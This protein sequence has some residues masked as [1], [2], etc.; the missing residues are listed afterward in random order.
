M[1][2][3]CLKHEG[4]SKKYGYPKMDGFIMENPIKLDDLWVPLFSE[5]RNI[6]VEIVETSSIQPF[7]ASPFTLD[8]S[9]TD[10]FVA[11]PGDS[12]CLVSNHVGDVFF[13]GICWFNSWMDSKTSDSN[14]VFF[15][16]LSW[17]SW[18]AVM[19]RYHDQGPDLGVIFFLRSGWTVELAEKTDMG[20]PGRNVGVSFEMGCG[21]ILA[22]EIRCPGPPNFKG[23]E[24]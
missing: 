11:Q 21:S 4:V 9:S 1:N 10:I 18:T 24:T 19:V 20:G 7:A 13:C 8:I 5:I 2:G 22:G 12:Q 23:H 15:W 3:T 14:M 16:G 17:T 6:Y